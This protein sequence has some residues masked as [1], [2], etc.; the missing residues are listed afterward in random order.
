MT[1]TLATTATPA[2]TRLH[3]ECVDI[4]LA[5]GK[6]LKIETSPQGD[7]LI[8][9]EVPEGKVWKISIGINITEEDA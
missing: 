5:A 1:I 7:E 2:K 9:T 8:D 4:E 6:S 3:G